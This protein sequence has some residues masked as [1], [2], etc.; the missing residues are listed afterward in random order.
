VPLCFLL[1]GCYGSKD[2]DSP[3]ASSDVQATVSSEKR[4]TTASRDGR[5]AGGN[6]SLLT[7]PG[8]GQQTFIGPLADAYARIDPRRDGWETEAFS[9]AAARTLSQFGELLR[10]DGA[11][12]RETI[13]QAISAEF[14]APSLFDSGGTVAYRDEH[15]KVTRVDTKAAA[16]GGPHGASRFLEL[17]DEYRLRFVPVESSKLKFKIVR[18]EPSDNGTQHTLVYFHADGQTAEGLSETSATWTVAWAPV[19]DEWRIRSIVVDE[20]EN[21]T[22]P[23]STESSFVDCTASVLARTPAY[24]TH[25]LR[26]TDYWRS[27]LPRALGLDVVANH[28]LAIGDVNG[29]DLD[30]IY[31]CQQGGLPNRLFIQQAD[32]T[33][34]DRSEESNADW[35]DYCAS[36]LLVDLDNDG[37]RDL[38]VGEESSI[39]LMEN[40]GRGRFTLKAQIDTLAQTFSLTAADFDLDGDLDIYCCGYN[41]LTDRARTGA[42]GEPVPYHDAQNG[43]KNLLLRNESGWRFSDA[44]DEVGLDQNNNRFSFA[45]SWEDFDNDGDSDLYVANDYGRNNLYR[46]DAGKFHDVAADLGVE[47]VSS[48]MSASWADFNRD[49]WMDLYISNMFSAAGNRITFQRQFRADESDDVKRQFQR[50]ARGNSLFQADGNGGFVDVSVPA[51][52][53]MGRWAWGSRFAD[54]NNDGWQDLIVANGFITTEDSGDL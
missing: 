24:A 9:A 29:D 20:Q 41:P 52:V 50:L 18:V 2:L 15:F 42:M 21:V 7:A 4:G 8:I 13:E 45:A 19:G 3:D 6:Q 51:G 16:I 5:S 36:A 37:D 47:D 12:S 17:R 14:S 54:F 31:W 43:G 49:G 39:A 27:R 28:G 25:I 35:L 23:N 40:D 38:V 10:A 44:T 33:L 26:G 30:D 53:T 48:G 1:A 32:G 46:N 22:R 11:A 34:A